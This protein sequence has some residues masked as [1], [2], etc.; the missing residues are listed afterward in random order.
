MGKTWIKPNI[1]AATKEEELVTDIRRKHCVV[2]FSKT[3][4][5]YSIKAKEVFD[6][7]K[8]PYVPIE[9]DTRSDGP[10][11]QQYLGKLTGESTVP[12]VFVNGEFVGGGSETETLYENGELIK[13]V[14][15]CRRI[16]CSSG[17]ERLIP[18]SAGSGD[19]HR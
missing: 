13:L 5:P 9:L 11:L 3:L 10:Q 2:I 4:C 14:N 8:V 15:K 16:V 19:C 7:M 12:R 1:S 6:D 17:E 18:S